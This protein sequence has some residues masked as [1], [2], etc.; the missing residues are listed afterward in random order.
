[1]KSTCNRIYNLYPN[2]I[3]KSINSR[4]FKHA[5]VER[6]I[7]KLPPVFIREEIGQSYQEHS[8]Q[9]ISWGKGPVK[10]FLWSQMHGDEA[11]GTM[12][13]FDLVNFL[14][15]EDPLVSLLW[16]KCTIYLLPMVNP[17]GAA[18]FNRR[19]AQQIDLNRDFLNQVA[20]E[21]KLLAQCRDKINPHFGF[22]L[23][24]QHTLWSVSGTFK[25]ATLSFLAPAA[26]P[27]LSITSGRKKAMQV[28]ADIFGVQQNY[29]PGQ[30]GLFDD[31]HEA[32]AFGDNFQKA[33]TATILIEAGGLQ[34]DP[35]KQQIRKY[36]FGSIIAGL[37]SIATN[38]YD[39][40]DLKNYFAIPK[41]TKQ[42][43]HLLLHNVQ[44]HGARVSIGIN[45]EEY[46][47]QLAQETY[48]EY[49]IEDIGDLR[50]FEAYETYDAAGQDMTG[51]I[52]LNK[53]AHF[54]L[55][56]QSE[57]ILS[58]ENGKLLK[59]QYIKPLN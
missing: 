17:D 34:N 52:W 56:R 11:T 43:F 37:Y 18:V 8:I 48:K 9:L 51:S 35:E 7:T 26:D 38:D 19:N 58:F 20:P 31:E 25:P 36:Y 5:D 29:L 10:V 14:Q 28:I 44:F 16:E 47:G 41:N 12:A 49:H 4:F 22:N 30:I 21:S 3:E 54:E 24:D 40:Q 53:P 15:Q 13:L 45:Y 2:F 39:H 1:M 6:L 27:E 46:P 50:N 32:R 55:L 57:T 33:G 42:L 59:K 23:H